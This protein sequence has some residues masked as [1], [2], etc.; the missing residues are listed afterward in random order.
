MVEEEA[1]GNRMSSEEGAE[2]PR[3]RGRTLRGGGECRNEGAG[4][5][6]VSVG[7]ALAEQQCGGNAWKSSRG[8]KGSAAALGE[9]LRLVI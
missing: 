5:M 1:V 3:T 6:G 9:V 4:G 2:V 8:R 7:G